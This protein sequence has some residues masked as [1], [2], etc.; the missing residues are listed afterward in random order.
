MLN[1]GTLLKNVISAVETVISMILLGIFTLI[2]M[3][4]N[5]MQRD[6]AQLENLSASEDTTPILA[7]NLYNR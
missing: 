7:T 1:F 4:V 2:M 3:G 6:Q 5:V